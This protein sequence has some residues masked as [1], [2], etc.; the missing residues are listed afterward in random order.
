MTRGRLRRELFG[1]VIA[2]DE[3]VGVGIDGLG[4]VDWAAR[5]QDV[6]TAG[7]A[8]GVVAER[9]GLA[10]ERGV[11][12]VDNAVETD[13]AIGLDLAFLL[14]EE[15]VGEIIAGQLDVRGRGGPA[16]DRRDAVEA[17]VWRVVILILDPRPE[18]AIEGGEVV[19]VRLE[20]GGQELAADRPK[21]AFDF[22][23]LQS[24]R[25]P[26]MSAIHRAFRSRIRFIRSRA[27][28]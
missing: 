20:E 17:A 1:A 18:T 23:L 27:L 22:P 15:E 14:E 12:F 3:T 26:G 7:G 13:G 28:A 24:C 16:V 9:D 6:D 5:K 2:P 8:G 19:R 11:D 4:E 21:P 10:D 25:L